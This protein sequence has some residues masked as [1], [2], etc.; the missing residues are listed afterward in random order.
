M[1]IL[2]LVCLFRNLSQYSFTSLFNEIRR[3]DVCLILDIEMLT[4]VTLDSVL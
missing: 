3:K 2:T 4:R 1:Y